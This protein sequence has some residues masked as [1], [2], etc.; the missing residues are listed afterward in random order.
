M[1]NPDLL[2]NI[3]Y[4]Y[5]TDHPKVAMR[6]I[7]RTFAG[8]LDEEAFRRVYRVTRA[9]FAQYHE[10]VFG[11]QITAGDGLF[12]AAMMEKV[13]PC[14]VIELGVASGY[15]AAFILTYAREMGLSLEVKRLTSFDLVDVTAEGKVTGSFL[16]SV[17]PELDAAWSL[18]TRA[19]SVE[20]MLEPERYLGSLPKGAILALVD[21]GHNH[22]WP[23]M[24]LACFEALLPHGSWIVMQDYQMM[25]RWLADCTRFGVPCPHPVR[26]VNLAVAHWPGTKLIGG[27]LAYNCA[28]LCLD[29]E[30]RQLAEFVRQMLRYPYEIEFNREDLIRRLGASA[31]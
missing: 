8:V 10:S 24:D 28:A 5:E 20:L 18:H 29:A 19:S 27:D 23:V 13:K 12:I 3:F 30:P 2:Q 4:G 25:E 11:G 6:W 1:S 17:Y 26:G 9:F 15:S 16:R 22:P 31:S 14:H 7:R 21:G